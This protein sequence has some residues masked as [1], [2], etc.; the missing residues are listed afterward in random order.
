MAQQL[1]CL[2]GRFTLAACAALAILKFSP[3]LAEAPPGS[4]PSRELVDAFTG[5][6][7]ASPYQYASRY[8]SVTFVTAQ[9]L[10]RVPERDDVAALSKAVADARVGTVL[11]GASMREFGSV[12]IRLAPGVD[13]DERLQQ[14]LGN[15]AVA[16]RDLRRGVGNPI[17]EA[18]NVDYLL[19]NQAIVQFKSAASEADIEALLARYCAQTIKR[20]QRAGSWR[21]VVRFDGQVA[22]HALAMTNRLTREGIVA[23]A[24]PD[25]IVVGETDVQGSLTATVGVTCPTVPPASVVDPYFPRQWHLEHSSAMP[26]DPSADINAKNAWAVAQGENVILAVLDDAVEASHEDL[27]GKIH[28]EWNAFDGDSNLD[29]TDRDSHGTPVAG[30]AGAMTENSHGIKATAP[31]VKLMLVRVMRHLEG[32]GWAEEHP[33]SVVVDGIEMAASSGA[34]VIS[35]SVSLGRHDMKSCDNRLPPTCQGDLEAAVGSLSDSAVLV[36]AAGNYDSAVVFPASLAGTMSNVIAVGATDEF[37]KI[38]TKDPNIEDDWGS[39]HGPEISVVAPGIKVLTTDRMGVKGFCDGNYVEFLGTSAS[40]PIVAGTAALMQSQYTAGGGAPLAPADLKIRLQ[41]TA[42]DFG[43]AG[44][45]E[46]YGHGRLDAC[47]AL[48]QDTCPKRRPWIFLL[49]ALALVAGIAWWVKAAAK[50]S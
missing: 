43:T 14:I 37:D 5:G 16:G 24:Q 22:R 17:Y 26:G 50:R 19:V 4:C 18:G 35:M 28:S 7:H 6:R 40:T 45:D 23:F 41:T 42:V 39:S 36:F 31:Q 25:F 3:A 47:K 1:F 8:E 44:F 13:P 10:P 34:S 49:A 46:F 9:G 38:K 12:L 29:I 30:I 32:P 11:Q 21:H 33:Y 27:A 15:A 20:R 2:R 48:M